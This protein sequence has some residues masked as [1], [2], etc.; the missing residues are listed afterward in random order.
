MFFTVRMGCGFLW[1]SFRCL[2]AFKL[3]ANKL[4]LIIHR[5]TVQEVEKA[6]DILMQNKTEEANMH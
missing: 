6:M 2:D 1:F 4:I 3:K 5:P